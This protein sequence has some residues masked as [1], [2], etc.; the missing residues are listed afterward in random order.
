MCW[1]RSSSHGD[2]NTNLLVCYSYDS[3][4]WFDI[5]IFSGRFSDCRTCFAIY[6]LT[7][8]EDSPGDYFSYTRL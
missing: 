8:N 6:P 7:F 3:I 2:S 1:T 5:V 4:N